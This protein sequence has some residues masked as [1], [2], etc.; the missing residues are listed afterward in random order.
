[1]IEDIQEQQEREVPAVQI[2]RLF[3]DQGTPEPTPVPGWDGC[4]VTLRPMDQYSRDKWEESGQSLKVQKDRI[5]KGE[6]DLQLHKAESNLALVTGT[7]IDWCF[8]F[9][10][11]SP[12][13]GTVK[14]TRKRTRS[15]KDERMR[16]L[17]DLYRQMDPT[18]A[19]W[20]IEECKRANGLDK[21]AE[22]D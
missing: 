12:D 3:I 16:E 8:T 10:A 13:G 20:L 1:M 17:A 22:Q 19:E 21:E 11:P 15:K 5:V 4:F 6:A 2:R 18:L 9:D 14:L 7:V